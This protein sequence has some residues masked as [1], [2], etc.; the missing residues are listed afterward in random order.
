MKKRMVA[1]LSMVSMLTLVISPDTAAKMKA[2]DN[3]KDTAEYIVKVDD[4][5]QYNDYSKEW[6][7]ENKRVVNHKE[8]DEK[9]L[10][11]AQSAAVEL[12]KD[13][14]KDYQEDDSLTVEKNYQLQASS[15][16]EEPRAIAVEAKDPDEGKSEYTNDPK[17]YVPLEEKEPEDTDKEIVPWNIAC[18][19]G[20]VKENQ[21]QGEG[22]KV[23]VIDSGIDT[24]YEL[25]TKD[26]MD[27]SDKTEGYKPTDNTGHGTEVAGVIGARINGTGM[28]GIAS[29]AQLYSVKVLDKE[30][31]TTISTVIK[32][33]EWCIENDMDIIN[34]SFGTDHYSKVLEEE[35]EKAH[36]KGIVMVS[37]AGNST[38]E[39]QYPAAYDHVISVGSINE[40]MEVSDFSPKEQTDLVAPGEK[41]QSTGYVGSHTISSGTSLAAAHV[42]GVAAA[43]K[44]ANP[45][46]EGEKLQQVLLT[47]AT[48]LSDGNKL[49]NYEAALSGM[50]GEVQKESVAKVKKVMEAVQEENFEDKV[51][52]S[53]N[54]D[55]WTDHSESSGHYSIINNMNIS[56]FSWG[57]SNDTQKTNNRMLVAGAA[58]L[59]DCIPS[60]SAS[61][62]GNAERD[63]N[64]KI[65]Y[66]YRADGELLR[67]D[68]GNPKFKNI[69]PNYSPYHGKSQ[70][71][72]KQV[73][74][75][76]SFLYELARRRL[77]LNSAFDMNVGNYKADTYHSI[78][79]DKQT[80]RRIIADMGTLYQ[81]MK[82]NYKDSAADVTTT[83]GM[84]YMILGV[85]LHLVQDIQAHRAIVTRKMVFPTESYEVG[86]DRDAMEVNAD[87]CKICYANIL[88]RDKDEIDITRPQKL[89][90]VIDKYNGIPF[91]RL[92]DFL[93]KNV[94]VYR[95]SPYEC[96]A[97]EGYEDNP[98]FFRRRYQSAVSISRY[99]IEDMANEDTKSDTIRDQN[100]YYASNMVPIY[101]NSMGTK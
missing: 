6:N 45:Q 73:V 90:T 37:A 29:K 28:V 79:I 23:A 60:L 5:Q 48:K 19:A 74:Q 13:E 93:I 70:Y 35:I 76:L 2:A 39:I 17:K 47:S 42:T 51:T 94:I 81:R 11:K 82:E 89:S 40:K 61:G 27:F 1:I 22:V 68:Q 30:N 57:A 14:V 64:G 99:Y 83:R 80:E 18:V 33:I 3:K 69:Y 53:W 56:Y 21:Y 8:Q 34:M 66:L 36:N 92:K 87:Q 100:T 91:I 62:E 98:Y 58:N 24:H 31:Q 97:A 44:S 20:N 54:S 67:D 26:W 95:Y 7:K 88:G 84:G 52:G 4:T 85:F 55:K 25:A 77:A 78:R 59:T 38:K 71:N 101:Q 32:A 43:I 50:D 12:S 9:Y 75:H 63:A 46:M 65:T 49:V 72:M 96:S 15:T 41:V 16:E 10:N 86:F